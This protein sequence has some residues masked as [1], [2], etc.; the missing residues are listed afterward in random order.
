[1]LF[2]CPNCRV[3]FRCRDRL[4]GRRIHCPKCRAV[5]RLMTWLL[6]MNDRSRN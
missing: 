5:L 3:K 6:R 4:L 1:M 2:L